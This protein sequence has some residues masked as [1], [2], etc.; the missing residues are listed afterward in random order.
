MRK[1]LIITAALLVLGSA[2]VTAQELVVEPQAMIY[3]RLPF[4]GGSQADR[5]TSFGLRMDQ[6]VHARGRVIRFDRLLQRPPLLALEMNR[7]GLRALRLA[8]RDYLHRYVSHRADGD[9]Q[10]ATTGAGED[11]AAATAEEDGAGEETESAHVGRD[12]SDTVSTIF[13]KT[14]AGIL[15]GVAFGAALLAGVGN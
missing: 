12:I 11:E 5:Q 13:E 14:P 3:Y 9:D 6:V 10:A 7:H 1:T 4:G 2:S 8:G 15:I